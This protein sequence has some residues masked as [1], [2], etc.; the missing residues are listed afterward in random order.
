LQSVISTYNSTAHSSIANLT[1]DDAG[2]DEHKELI[3]KLNQTK[4]MYN[5]TV[6]DLSVG[7]FVRVLD[8]F[9]FKQGTEPKIFGRN[10]HSCQKFKVMQSQ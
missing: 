5:K 3:V 4:H 7:D 1:P 8:T 10:I 6:S 2:K 9:I